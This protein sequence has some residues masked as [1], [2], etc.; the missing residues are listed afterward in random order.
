MTNCQAGHTTHAR[1]TV[2]SE[3]GRFLIYDYARYMDFK[4][5]CTGQDDVSRTIG[6]YGIWDEP[7]TGLIASILDNGKENLFIDVGCHI[8]WFSKLALGKGAF[9]LGFDG[10]PEHI[11]LCK[12][13]APHGAYKSI[14]FDK[15][16]VPTD[17]IHQAELIKIDVEG[18]EQWAIKYF[19]KS[20]QAGTIKN[21]IIEIT[22][23]FNDSYPALVQRMIDWGYEVFRY[24]AWHK[25]DK[26]DGEF[27]FHQT[28]FLFKKQ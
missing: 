1:R 17:R 23:V 8:G 7:S 24:E 14:W 21:A 13:N 28:D 15:S 9:V 20:F 10:E 4:G 12:F 6:M 2:P 27:N 19:E 18:S 25:L 16:I 22:P 3:Q 5:Y 26:W 11:E